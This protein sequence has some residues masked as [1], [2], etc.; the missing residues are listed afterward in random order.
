VF[1][2]SK[3]AQ[4][5]QPQ[6]SCSKDGYMVHAPD[7]ARYVCGVGRN[8]CGGNGL[9]RVMDRASVAATPAWA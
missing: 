1:E 7:R 3:I 5:D 2:G 9:A 8:I 6:T 4:Q